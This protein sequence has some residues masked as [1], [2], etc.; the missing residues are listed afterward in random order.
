MRLAIVF[1]FVLNPFL[2]RRLPLAVTVGAI[3]EPLELVAAGLG[4]SHDSE[5]R[6]LAALNH[7]KIKRRPASE[8]R[9]HVEAAAFIEWSP[10]RRKRKP[11]RLQLL[12]EKH[13]EQ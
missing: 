9:R 8:H 6:R 10:G 12:A 7:F 13:R 1:F 5:I 2:V 4:I 3:A 11:E